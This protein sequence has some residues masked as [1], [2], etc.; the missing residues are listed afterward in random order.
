M[1]TFTFNLEKSHNF[2][3][4]LTKCSY[5]LVNYI[6]NVDVITLETNWPYNR[7]YFF[8]LNFQTSNRIFFSWPIRGRVPR[9][10]RSVSLHLLC[11]GWLHRGP[12][13]R[14]RGQGWPADTRN[15]WGEMMI[16]KNN[17]KVTADKTK[18]LDF[19][20]FH[21]STVFHIS[22]VTITGTVRLY[23]CTIEEF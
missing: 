16:K 3:R 5:C 10:P 2:K 14:R 15:V 13:I 21:Q 22:I 1:L 11:G 17:Q 7:L 8:L 12:D 23:H 9:W 19:C 20:Y 18:K 6:S 4:L